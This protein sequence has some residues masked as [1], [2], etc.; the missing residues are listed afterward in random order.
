MAAAIGEA[1]TTIVMERMKDMMA[2]HIAQ[3]IF[4]RNKYPLV[5]PS[6]SSL[7]LESELVGSV[8]G[9]KTSRDFRK[10]TPRTFNG[11]LENPTKAKLWLSSIETIFKYMKCLE[12]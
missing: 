2:E 12:E 4:R 11:S 10:Y 8:L 3:H 6:V 9:S 5:G 1:V 7:G